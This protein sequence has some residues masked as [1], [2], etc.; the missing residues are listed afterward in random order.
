MLPAA[1]QRFRSRHPNV[2]LDFREAFT[3]PQFQLLS[4]RKLDVGLVRFNGEEEVPGLVLREMTRDRLCA[5][6]PAGHRLAG[7][8][9]VHLAELAGEPVIGYPAG[10]GNW[11]THRLQAIAYQSGFEWRITQ[12]A[13]EAT[14][15]I[16]LVAA[17]LGLAVLPEPLR[18]VHLPSVRY[19]PLLDEQAFI[20]V[21]AAW[22]DD[23]GSPLV[24]SFIHALEAGGTLTQ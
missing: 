11:L 13:G 23:D 10:N 12:T 14:T 24:A 8:D 2:H 16:G 4:E 5:I 19:V 15:Q 7:R 20:A 21:T 1:I 9:G 3:Q 6:V 22:R 18:C 17:G